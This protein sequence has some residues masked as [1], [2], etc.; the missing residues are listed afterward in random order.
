M[1]MS[2]RLL[3]SNEWRDDLGVT[4]YRTSSVSQTSLNPFFA[5]SPGFQGT[6]LYR[7]GGLVPASVIFPQDG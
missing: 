6:V 3:I 7:S 5:L 4:F 1:L 2:G